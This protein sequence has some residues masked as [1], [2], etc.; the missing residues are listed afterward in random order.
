MWPIVSTI[1]WC[2]DGSLPHN[3]ACGPRQQEKKR[4]GSTSKCR[5]YL[6]SQ[7]ILE[8]D[9]STLLVTATQLLCVVVFCRVGG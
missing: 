3:A 8:E 9:S 5:R 6:Q 4:N 7:A 2:F 1:A